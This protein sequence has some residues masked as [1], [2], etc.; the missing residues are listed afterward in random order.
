M[1]PAEDPSAS[2]PL[3]PRKAVFL[4]RDGTIVADVGYC[5]D[6]EKIVL[7]PGAARALH[8]LRANG[9]GLFLFTNQSGIGRGYFPRER[10]EKCNWQMEELLGLG[11]A[12]FLETCIA[13]EAPDDPMH[14]RKPSPRFILESIA[15]HS[16]DPATTWMVGDKLTD[17]AAGLAAGVQAALIGAGRPE[18]LP[19]GVPVFSDLRSFAH[20]IIHRARL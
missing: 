7:L 12:L 14:Y 18:G 2:G 6:P 16:L 10:V 13:P 4:D 9:F 17:A 15:K 1:S 20:T 8:E 5:S 3:T 11:H 19:G